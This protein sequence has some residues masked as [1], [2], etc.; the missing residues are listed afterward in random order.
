MQI[1]RF[2]NFKKVKMFNAIWQALKASG[3]LKFM[4]GIITMMVM[5]LP[6]RFNNWDNK[7]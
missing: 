4:G 1:L 3:A 5:L 2:L 6:L 7:K